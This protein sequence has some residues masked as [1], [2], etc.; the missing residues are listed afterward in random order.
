MGVERH[1]QADT[2]NHRVHVGDRDHESAQQ[3]WANLPAVSRERAM[4]STDQ[5]AVYTGVMPAAQHKAMMKHARKTNP[6]E[7]FH[8]TM[9]QRVSR[10]V[11][12][13]RAFSKTL[14]NHIG[15]IQDFICHD[16]VTR[17][18]ALPV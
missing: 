1:G 4:F 16:N 15:A 8:N 11:R 10:L 17:A 14:A 12:D 6:I 13:T 18:A 3:V 2:A 9:R 5:Y 7:R